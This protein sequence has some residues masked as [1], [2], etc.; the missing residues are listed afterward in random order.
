MHLFTHH[1]Y[2]K[3][4]SVQQGEEGATQVLEIL[5]EEFSLAMALAGE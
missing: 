3:C 4:F 5:K 1:L 2:I